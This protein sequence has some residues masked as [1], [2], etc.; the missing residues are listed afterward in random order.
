[1]ATYG[2]DLGTTDSRIA[3]VDD[4]GRPVILKSAVGE[5]STPSAVLFESSENV[6][7]G[8]QAKDSALLAPDLVV[9]QV[10]RRMGT[11]VHYLLCGED[12]TPESI[13]AL[14]LRELT[15]AAQEETGEVVRDVVM[16]VP[17][18]FGVLEREATRRA[19]Q[20]AGLNVL[21]VLAEPVAAALAYQGLGAADGPRHVFIYD[22]G[23]GTFATTVIRVEGNNIRVVCTDGDSGLGG[24]DWDAKIKDFL[25]RSFT[26]QYPQVDP[27]GDKPFMQDLATSAE[28]LKV[29]L[30]ATMARKHTVRFHGSVVQVELT[31][32]HLEQIT[33]ELLER[34]LEITEQTIATA[35][36]K[37]VSHFDEVLLVG[38][39]TA[40]PVISQMLTE[41]FGLR[42]RSRDP[43]LAVAKG[44]AVFA[45]IRKVEV[46]LPEAREEAS[47]RRALEEV[48]DQLGISASQVSAMAAMNVSTVVSRTIGIKVTDADDPLFETDPGK[49]REYIAP[50]LPA[51]T[52]L[53]AETRQIF[54]TAN[55]NQRRAAIE[56][57]EQAGSVASGKL[58]HNI[59]IGQAVLSDLPPRPDG[60]PFEVVFR[61]TE[62]GLLKIH[63]ME[64]DSGRE[65]RFEMQIGGLNE[66]AIEQARAAVASYELAGMRAPG[67][68][69]SLAAEEAVE[70]EGQGTYYDDGWGGHSEQAAQ[71]AAERR[72]EA[73]LGRRVAE[74][75][76][77]AEAE[78]R[79]EQA[80]AQA[81]RE[82]D[83]SAE[84]EER[85][86]AAAA[87]SS[88]PPQLS[89]YDELVHS[90]FADL[91]KPGRLLFNPPDRMHLDQRERVEVR[92]T[93]TLGLDAELLEHLRGPGEPQLEEIP[94]A[95]LM[96]VTLKS[97]AFQITA[98]SDE[99]Q[100]VTPDGITT[101]EFDIRALKRGSQRLVMCVSL[102]IPVG[103]QSLEHKSIPVR[104]AVINVEVGAPAL[105]AHFVSDNWQWFIGTAVAIAAV[106]VAVLFH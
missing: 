45:L 104:E 37:G 5:D 35:R 9:E 81:D 3:Y 47:T 12:H 18:Y 6:V 61:M 23:G 77:R 15:R 100:S 96:A 83:D 91:V 66:A 74:R 46:S 14:I 88:A 13:S 25:L 79:A 19:G 43:Q 69:S 49:A 20:I 72:A 53:P 98:Y 27:S 11:D 38:G 54:R 33:S 71:E 36:Q 73:E 90:A 29:A 92:L 10:K 7:V 58:E 2:I 52:P 21:G 56:V 84:M 94:T 63:A 28:Q 67:M 102:R 57:W 68:A 30:S 8:R 106:L 101:W 86:S 99:E 42:A 24:A 82:A 41:R 44:A 55:D 16:T 50:V 17:A 39:M 26:D 85:Q 95:P 60:A 70:P 76:A 97:E 31:R 105:V 51:N 65:V 103:G 89:V 4:T 59:R 1:M 32:E 78:R 80:L 64:T 87:Q 34:T 22:L 62:T 75:R 93:R 40:M 48:A